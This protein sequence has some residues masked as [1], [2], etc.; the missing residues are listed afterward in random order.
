MESVHPCQDGISAPM[1]SGITLIITIFQ[2]NKWVAF[3]FS[4]NFHYL[5][6]FTY[7]NPS[8]VDIDAIWR[9]VIE[10]WRHTST[11]LPYAFSALTYLASY[12]HPRK[13]SL[14][15]FNNDFRAD[16]K[17]CFPIA[18]FPVLYIYSYYSRFSDTVYKLNLSAV[19][20]KVC[21]IAMFVTVTECNKRAGVFATY[22]PTKIHIL[23]SNGSSVTAIK[24]KVLLH[25]LF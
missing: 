19:T 10:W 12:S 9:F 25:L 16:F 13:I 3:N 21:I 24:Q 23:S 18:A 20:S 4:F 15:L 17:S 14:P 22:L 1:C 6:N 2:W 5:R 8:Y 7:W 11:L